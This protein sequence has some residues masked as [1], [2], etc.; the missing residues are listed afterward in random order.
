LAD[1]PYIPEEHTGL[2]PSAK[3]YRAHD[4]LGNR[5]VRLKVLLTDHESRFALDRE[6]LTQRMAVLVQI[7]HPLVARLVELDVQEQDMTLVSEFGEGIDGWKLIRHQPLTEAHLRTLAA[8]LVTA[9]QAGEALN[10]PH[11]DLKPS[12]LIIENH[13]LYGLRLKLQDW[14]VAQSR[15]GQPRETLWFRAPELGPEDEPTARSDLFSA[16]ATLVALITGQ[17]LGEG[18]LAGPEPAG[19]AAFDAL[20]LRSV[21]PDIDPALLDWLA[22]L[23][24]RDPAQ[25]P[26]SATQA[27]A[28][29]QRS[30]EPAAQ[31]PWGVAA[32][33][34]VYNLAVLAM[35]IGYLWWLLAGGHSG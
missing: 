11:G 2:G 1:E 14:G 17:V 33:I 23:L 3:V 8:Q 18:D 13:P 9:L 28:A 5:V 34:L 15:H 27:L 19:W 12:N 32:L 4:H 6:H 25:R 21:R 16:A 10:L 26:D 29:L 31:H 22:R 24:H 35:L 30:A 20:R 7:H